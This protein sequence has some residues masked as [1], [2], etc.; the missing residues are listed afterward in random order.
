M[1]NFKAIINARKEEVEKS[2]EEKKCKKTK[3]QSQTLLFKTNFHDAEYVKSRASALKGDSRKKA[4]LPESLKDS[5]SLKIISL[6]G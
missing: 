4:E 5:I 6:R 3:I 2:K 1:E